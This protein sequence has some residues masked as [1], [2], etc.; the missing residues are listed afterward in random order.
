MKRKRAILLVHGYASD[1]TDFAPIIPYLKARYDYVANHDLPGHGPTSTARLSDFY[2]VDVFRFVEKISKKLF[3]QYDEVDLMGFSMGG[4]I[5][6]YLASIFP[7]RK[8]VLLAPANKFLNVNVG[9][10]RSKLHFNYL[11]ERLGLKKDKELEFTMKGISLDDKKSLNMAF[12]TLI[13]NYTPHSLN[14]FMQV[15]DYCNHN[16]EKIMITKPV[17]ILHG[18]VDQL[19]PKASIDY[20]MQ[21]CLNC[22]YEYLKG[23]SHLMILSQNNE[24]MMER[25]MKF[26]KEG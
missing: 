25:I 10:A 5:S 26:L 7:F 8:V 17:L 22:E 19:V 23:I 18:D 13:P 15:I 16:L 1:S 24:Y 2:A 9:I 21:H 14:Q 6:T 11:L 12:K 3:Q 20:I 4:A